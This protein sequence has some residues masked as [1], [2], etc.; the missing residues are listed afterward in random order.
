MSSIIF[1]FLFIP[2][3][4]FILLAVNIIFTSYNLYIKKNSVF[5]YDFS[6]FLN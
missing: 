1:F 6:L 5:K 3:L 2:L 4:T